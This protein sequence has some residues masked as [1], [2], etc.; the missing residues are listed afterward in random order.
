MP[1]MLVPV[2][3]RS[4]KEIRC[5]LCGHPIN[6]EDDLHLCYP[7]GRLMVALLSRSSA[8]ACEAIVSDF[9]SAVLN[10]AVPA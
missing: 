6:S 2:P 8:T 9:C 5:A 3:V 10:S 7:C 4:S 1:L